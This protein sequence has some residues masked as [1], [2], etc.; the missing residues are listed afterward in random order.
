MLL[1]DAVKSIKKKLR[2]TWKKKTIDLT[3]KWL[4]HFITH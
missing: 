4:K 3:L 1:H 2:N